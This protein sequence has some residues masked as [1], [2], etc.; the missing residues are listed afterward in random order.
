MNINGIISSFNT[1]FDLNNSNRVHNIAIAAKQL[2]NIFIDPGQKISFNDV[3]G[4]RTLD[5][6]YKVANIIVDNQLVEEIGYGFCQ[7][8]STLY[9]TVLLSGLEITGRYNYS[10]PVPDVPLELDATVVNGVLDLKF[11]NSTDTDDYIYI[12]TE[13]YRYAI[14]NGL[15][16]D[17]TT[18]I[19]SL[20]IVHAMFK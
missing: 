15:C 8:S 19:A 7:V 12:K 18:L 1:S 10:I 2:N 3:T 9:N 17:F 6:E 4:S 5:L 11:K 16:A 20:L 14:H 13:I